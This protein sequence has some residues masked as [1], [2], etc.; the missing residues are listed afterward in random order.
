MPLGSVDNLADVLGQ[1]ADTIDARAEAE[2]VTNSYTA[3]LLAAGP[4]R[5]AKKIGEEGVELALAIAGGTSTDITDESADLIYHLLVALASR[6]IT[7]DAV[8]KKIA[9]RQG[10]SGL[11]E[12]AAR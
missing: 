2:D 5:T 4:H 10:I 6:E 7:L 11:R 9:K 12:K 8:A 1:L 3:Q